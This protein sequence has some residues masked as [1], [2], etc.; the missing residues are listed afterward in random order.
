MDVAMNVVIAMLTSTVISTVLSFLW[1]AR[2]ENPLKL[3]FER[4]IEGIKSR[5]SKE[6]EDLRHRYE[7]ETERL[8]AE[9]IINAETTHEL[10]ERRLAAYPK[11]VELVYRI[12]NMAREI[13]STAETNLVLAS[14]LRAR[15]REL[16][17]GLYSS[18]FDLER[19]GFF[20]PV[21]TYKNLAINFN[22]LVA[23]RDYYYSRGDKEQTNETSARLA[24]L[25]PEIDN[26]HKCIAE[27]L[28]GANPTDKQNQAR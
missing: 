3:H 18:R 11:L 26:Q 25:Y 19:D 9:L 27:S 12:R 10:T 23:D 5:H 1:K 8:K 4:E 14:E 2:F 7:L 13:A 20:Y 16:E 24:D 21:H 17:N 6:L 22:G 28:S 15:T